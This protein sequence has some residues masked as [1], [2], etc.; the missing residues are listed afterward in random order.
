MDFCYNWPCRLPKCEDIL[1]PWLLITKNFAIFL[2]IM[3]RYINMEG[4]NH[5]KT[6]RQFESLH[7]HNGPGLANIRGVAGIEETDCF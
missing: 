2:L 5:T 6:M 1:W 4:A 3:Q 7:A